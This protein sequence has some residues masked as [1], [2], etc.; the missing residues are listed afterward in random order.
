MGLISHAEEMG[1]FLSRNFA[2]FPSVDN[3]LLVDLDRREL[4]LYCDLLTSG[5]RM[6]R[7]S[8]RY[9]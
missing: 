1:R 7:E 4:C 6:E 3:H 9:D 5:K 8:S 2:G